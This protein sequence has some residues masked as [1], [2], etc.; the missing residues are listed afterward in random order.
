[1]N[2]EQ[3]W[4]WFSGFTDGEGC[5]FIRIQKNK[6]GNYQALPMFQIALAS[7]DKS[8]LEQIR[9]KLRCGKIYYF[10]RING[11][12]YY[13]FCIH[14]KKTILSKLIPLLDKHPLQSN[15]RKDYKMFKYI[16]KLCPYGKT[17]NDNEI[18]IIEQLKSCMNRG[19]K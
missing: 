11:F 18:K 12:D 9:R 14:S 13:S 6:F 8:I 15:K 1:M 4:W 3:F 19:R 10:K 5:F 7:R 17:F 16:I 2:K